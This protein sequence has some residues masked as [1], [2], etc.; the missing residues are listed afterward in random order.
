MHTVTA[1]EQANQEKNA[2]ALAS[3]MAA[4][5]LT[6]FKLVVGIMTNSLGIL[7]EAAHS[8]LDLVAAL[9]T[10]F[11]VRWSG[12]P[13]DQEHQYGHGK[14]ENLSALF[15]TGLLLLTCVWIIYEALRRLL[16]Q[17]AVVDATFWAFL[18]MFVSIGVD[19]SRSRML[20]R[21]AIKYNS[22]ALE[23]DA[24][25]FS[26]DIWS[27]VVVILGLVGVKLADNYLQFQRLANADAIAA[28]LVACIV[29]L[30]SVRLGVRAV[31]GLLDR[32]PLGLREQ[33]Q[34][35]AQSIAG[36]VDC[37]QVRVRTSGPEMFVDLHIT[38]DPQLSLQHA[39]DLTEQV[40]EAIQKLVPNADVTVHV[41]PAEGSSINTN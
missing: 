38:V 32:A 26:T 9:V 15:E 34:E 3:V 23:A 30:I 17:T 35:T 11:A 28:L 24:L 29:I 27:S 1:R 22:Q 19:I 36:V 18:V 25:H 4:I 16:F 14:V 20:S 13:A 33:V 12:H 31:Q 6:I 39:H 37:H 8:G 41:E 5:G 21:T 40:E 7:A 2:V 10:F